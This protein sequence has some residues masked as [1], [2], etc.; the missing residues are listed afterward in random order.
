MHHE[1]GNREQSSVTNHGYV[2][3]AVPACLIGR[4]VTKYDSEK[5][6]A[7]KRIT[8]TEEMITRSLKWVR[9]R[10]SVT[11]ENDLGDY[12]VYSLTGT[13]YIDYARENS[14]DSS[15]I[16]TNPRQAPRKVMAI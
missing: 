11:D 13:N 1:H 7:K 6:I 12:G 14:R 5:K 15:L 4:S 9:K 2:V 10:K 16:T 3:A 8:H